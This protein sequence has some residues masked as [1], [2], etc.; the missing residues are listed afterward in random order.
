MVKNEDGRRRRRR[1]REAGRFFP[2]F[3]SPKWR[4]LFC[5]VP[6]LFLSLSLEIMMRPSVSS[7]PAW[8]VAVEKKRRRTGKARDGGSFFLFLS[9]TATMTKTRKARLLF[10]ARPLSCSGAGGACAG[11]QRKRETERK[12]ETYLLAIAERAKEETGTRRQLTS[13]LETRERERERER[14]SEARKVKNFSARQGKKL[15]SRTPSNDEPPQSPEFVFEAAFFFF[16][17]EN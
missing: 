9:S 1:R 3:S 4:P 15:P 17:Q 13:E 2:L 7:R 11:R 14:F 10:L 5:L 6:V 8:S 12:G 16:N